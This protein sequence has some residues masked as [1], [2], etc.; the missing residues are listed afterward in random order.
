MIELGV[1]LVILMGWQ[2]AAAEFLGGAAMILLLALLGGWVL[3]RRLTDPARDR[4]AIG[5][6]AAAT[7]TRRWSQRG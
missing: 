1:V 3:S 7:T 2:F 6:A 5:V 4:A